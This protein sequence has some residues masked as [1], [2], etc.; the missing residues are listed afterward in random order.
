[1]R[2]VTRRKLSRYRVGL[3]CAQMLCSLQVQA[4]LT[5]LSYSWASQV[6]F[7]LG[8]GVIM[9]LNLSFETA[10]SVANGRGTAD[11]PDALVEKV[12]EEDAKPT[13]EEDQQYQVG[14]RRRRYV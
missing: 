3:S 12:A 11:E 8:C 13:P 7:S 1:M 6:L 14:A 2:R 4:S 5:Y 10:G 9:W